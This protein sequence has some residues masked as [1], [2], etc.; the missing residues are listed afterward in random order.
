M[1]SIRNERNRDIALGII[2]HM[3]NIRLVF[4]EG[5]NVEVTGSNAVLP[6]ENC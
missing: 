6:S 3:Q 5:E 1:V 4:S 2:K